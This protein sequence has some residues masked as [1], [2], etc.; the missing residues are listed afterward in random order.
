MSSSASLPSPDDDYAA[1]LDAYL[2]KAFWDA[3]LTSVGARIRALEAVKAGW[4]ELINTGTGQ[5]LAVIQANVEPQLVALTAVINQLKADVA[6]AEDAIAVIVS[7]GVNISN[8][9]GLTEVL[10]AKAGLSDLDTAVAELTSLMGRYVSHAEAQSLTPEQ[11]AQALSNLGLDDIHNTLTPIVAIA[12]ADQVDFVLG[13]EVSPGACLVFQNGSKLSGTDYGLTT[14]TLSL[15]TPAAA[16][17][18]VAVIAIGTFEVANVL[19]PAA[20]L[21]DLGNPAAAR[22]NLGLGSAAVKNAG[23]GAGEVLLLATA[24]ELPALNGKNL[25][26]TLKHGGVLATTAGVS[27]DFVGI[28]ATAER[29]TILFDSVSLSG[30]SNMLLQLG[31]GVIQTTDYVSTGHA[32]DQSGNSGATAVTNGMLI[33]T[34]LATDTLIGKITLERLT[35]NRWVATGV[36]R[37]S[38]THMMFTEGIVTLAGALDRL[39]LL[40]SNGTDTFDGGQV[41]I[42]WE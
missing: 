4:E 27:V 24:N 19:T 25:V 8:V 36:C 38:G 9:V 40:S 2:N 14:T 3:A 16:G 31:S 32:L 10:S 1:P 7:G 33:Y 20:N 5:A 23:T 37:K 30:T 22:A 34:I 35:G 42:T 12:T 29:V 28:P 17:D 26:G 39:R 15:A 21:A 41:G 11:K 18:V 13:M 6:A